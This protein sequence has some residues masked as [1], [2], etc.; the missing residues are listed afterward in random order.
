MDA[1]AEDDAQPSEPD[2][3]P[4]HRRRRTVLHRR[5]MPL[6][7]ER[8]RR[9]TRRRRSELGPEGRKWVEQFMSKKN[10]KLKKKLWRSFKQGTIQKLLKKHAEQVARK[11]F[12]TPGKEKESGERRRNTQGE[13]ESTKT[14]LR[15]RRRRDLIHR[16]RIIHRRRRSG[17]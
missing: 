4:A 13:E 10:K 5:R 2:G 9:L 8:R 14:S 16:R 7:Q 17:E 1:Q 11:M 3:Y 15:H 6:P 12:P